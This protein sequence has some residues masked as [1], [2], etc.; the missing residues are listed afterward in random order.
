MNTVIR[1]YLGLTILVV[2]AFAG[3]ACGPAASAGSTSPTPS[4]T[5]EGVGTLGT[6][7]P[8]SSPSAPAGPST[9]KAAP[10]LPQTA[11]AYA[12]A[13]VAAW[14]KGQLN[15]L[16]TLTTA[17]V[18]EQLLEIPDS[19]DDNWGFLRCDG[20]AG[21][22]YCSFANANGD[23]LVLRISHQLLGKAHAATE[24]TLDETE[25]PADGVAYVKEFVGAWQFGNTARMLKLSSPAIVEKVSAAPTNPTYPAPTC[26][27]GGLLQVKVTWGAKTA[28]FDVGTI[29]LGGPNAIIGYQL[30]GLGLTS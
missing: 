27:G 7:D 16:A 25:Y 21:S 26:C 29:K 30:E 4:S 6:P 28:R 2:A 24:V 14:T 23:L 15:K 5:T 9:V 1:R 13:V 17:L 11:E 10:A 18:N 8:T 12:K 19:Y 3:A 20:A 22:S